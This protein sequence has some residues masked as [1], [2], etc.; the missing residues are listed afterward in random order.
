[1]T[2]CNIGDNITLTYVVVVIQTTHMMYH[3]ESL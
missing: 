2:C 3:D 1:M